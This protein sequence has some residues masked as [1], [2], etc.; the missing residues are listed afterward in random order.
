MTND[1]RRFA[2]SPDLDPQIESAVW[3]VVSEPID[4]YKHES[5]ILKRLEQLAS[6][7][8]A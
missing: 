2:S 5:A 7:K 3:S 8:G 6:Q 1:N 4:I